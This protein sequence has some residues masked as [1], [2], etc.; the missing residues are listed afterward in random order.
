MKSLHEKDGSFRLYYRQGWAVLTV[1]PPQPQGRPVYPENVYNK[2]RILR[3]PS[4]NQAAIVSVV[5]EA[6][7]EPVP[8]VPWPDGEKL[9]Q[10]LS[11][12]IR[13]DG[14]QAAITVSPPQYGGEPLSISKLE[15]AL[16]DAGVSQGIKR[17]NLEDLLKRKLWDYPVI[18]AEGLV[19]LH[20]KRA[21]IRFTFETQRGKPFK[22][23]EFGRIDLKELNF[24]QNKKKDELLAAIDEP[25]PPRDGW[26]VTGEP[27]PAEPAPPD[28]AL[29][30]GEGV[31]FEES[32]H[33][34]YALRDGNAKLDGNTLT[35]EPYLD[36]ENVDYSNGNIDFDGSIGIK[37]R[38]ADGFTV[39]A[40]GTIEIGKSV[41]RVHVESRGDI[42]LKAG[43]NG[44]EE[45][46]IVCGGDLYAK[47]I[48]SAEIRCSGNIYVEE[49]IM[50][51][52]VT[53]GGE[54]I[55]TG[56]H[57]EIFGGLVAAEGSLRCR[58]LGN[59]NEP[60]TTLYIGTPPKELEAISEAEVG[61][62]ASA[63]ELNKVKGNIGQLKRVA[64]GSPQHEQA[65]KALAQLTERA[66]ALQESIQKSVSDLHE[67]RLNLPL[68]EESSVTVEEHIYRRVTV[69]FGAH[70]WMAPDKGTGGTCLLSRQGS[71][72][73]KGYSEET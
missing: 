45:G 59:L 46:R 41:S 58:K 31:R 12:E 21:E 6:A 16:A 8:V 51:S 37:N 63:A 10:T 65:A 56:R 55:L 39:K 19:P 67:K 35:V 52:R 33:S 57:A 42:I 54:I 24:I 44:A 2:M 28:I 30:P 15:N 27:L 49:A 13:E 18:A 72:L 25:T 34:F 23:K 14:M 3:I 36:L 22:E 7:G 26:K 68:R 64:P 48:E 61:I 40:S 73:E 62:A 1:F 17:D 29:I 60:P 70:S 20:G 71:I 53:A 69:Y 38:I 66:A 11:V 9:T 32:Q 5:Q 50:H 43:I 4:Y 47:Y